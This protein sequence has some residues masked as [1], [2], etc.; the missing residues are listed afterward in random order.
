MVS[1]SHSTTGNSSEVELILCC[2]RAA[3]GADEAKSIQ[4]LVDAGVNW[5]TLIRQAEILGVMPLL[6]RSQ[7]P[8]GAVP[9]A[10]RARLDD[11][12]RLNALRNLLLTRELV[13]ILQLFE[14]N[15]ID[16][17]PLKGPTLATLAFGDLAL[18]EFGDLD[19]LLRHNDILKAAALLAGREYELEC[20]FT[21]EQLEK[22]LRSEHIHHLALARAN[23][24]IKVELHWELMQA[25][26]FFTPGLD[27]VWSRRT[28]CSFGGAQVTGLDP[29]DLLIFLCLHGWKHRWLKLG[30]IADLAG[31]IRNTPTIEWTILLQR[32]SDAG[33][34]R[35]VLLGL[36]L[37]QRLL[38]TPLPV[39]VENAIR[40]D[41]PL[42]R[43]IL[44]TERSLFSQQ[45]PELLDERYEEY[46]HALEICDGMAQRASILCAFVRKTARLNE[47]DFRWIA[48]PRPLFFLYYLLRPVRLATRAAARAV[49]RRGE[50]RRT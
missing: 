16:A 14:E 40:S 39:P 5:D 17:I 3:F 20:S 28:E 47:N 43:L 11:Y 33:A 2:T 48:F 49:R 1:T 45:L 36:G 8:Q 12:F 7:L 26:Y 24:R 15:G 18:R 34:R 46:R 32:A 21:P 31:L 42:G 50:P 44:R 27:E 22:E 25:C 30:W 29:E 10:T 13:S 37:A 38:H 41:R 6:C 35:R 19:I 4:E 9:P 23:G